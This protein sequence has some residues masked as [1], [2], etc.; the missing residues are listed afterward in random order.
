M[1]EPTGRRPLL[2]LVRGDGLTPWPRDASGRELPRR[3]TRGLRVEVRWGEHQCLFDR[4]S[5]V[6]A[7]SVRFRARCGR[8]VVE[9]VAEDWE[10]W[11]RELTA[12]GQVKTHAPGCQIVRCTGCLTNPDKP[13]SRRARRPRLVDGAHDPTGHE[14]P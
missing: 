9:R 14:G 6:A 1:P 7:S 8:R 10:G 11:L 12:T 13:P 2:T 3:P 5:I 4:W